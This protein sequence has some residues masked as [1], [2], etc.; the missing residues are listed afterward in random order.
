MKQSSSRTFSVVL[1]VQILVVLYVRG[2]QGLVITVKHYDFIRSTSYD[3]MQANKVVLLQERC[4][5][6]SSM[7]GWRLRYDDSEDAPTHTVGNLFGPPFGP[8]TQGTYEEPRP[9]ASWMGSLFYNRDPWKP[10]MFR[11]SYDPEA[12]YEW[13]LPLEIQRNGEPFVVTP[14]TPLAVNDT[15]D[16]TNNPEDTSSTLSEYQGVVSCKNPSGTGRI[17]RRAPNFSKPGAR[18]ALDY[19]STKR[20]GEAD[21]RT[22]KLIISDLEYTD[23]KNPVQP[24]ADPYPLDLM[25]ITEESS[26]A[27]GS[28]A[29]SIG[30]LDES[31]GSSAYGTSSD[32]SAAESISEGSSE[33]FDS[34]EIS[35]DDPEWQALVKELEAEWEQNGQSLEDINM[36]D[37]EIDQVIEQYLAS[38]EAENFDENV[39]R[40]QL[41]DVGSL[42]SLDD[43][44]ARLEDELAMAS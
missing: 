13:R 30:A 20:F 28:T 42:N 31:W 26:S 9:W 38:P 12:G 19:E 22:V 33:E 23:P 17:L 15:L 2:I 14:T 5:G 39:L 11:T 40:Y 24:P 32:G 16:V 10:M 34:S 18:I 44:I 6:V 29:G 3:L 8:V 35:E 7:P 25:P 21:C 37:V 41:E 4:D 1:A 27:S 43:E 36:D